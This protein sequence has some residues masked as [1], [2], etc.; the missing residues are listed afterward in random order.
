LTPD[1][2]AEVSSTVPGDWVSPPTDTRL[3]R[4][5]FRFQFDDDGQFE[6]RGNRSDAPNEPSYVRQGHYRLDRGRLI[7]PALNDGR[8][9][10]LVTDGEALE[11]RIDERLTFRLRRPT[12]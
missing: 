9:V 11:L 3:G 7:S 4:L 1:P 5:R 12:G 6:V 8:P 10:T 2:T